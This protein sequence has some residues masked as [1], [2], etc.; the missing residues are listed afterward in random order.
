MKIRVYYE[1][2]DIAGVVYYAN[3]FKFIERARSE[4]FFSQGISPIDGASHFV[5]KSVS[6][7]FLASAKFGDEIDVRTR[8][9]DMKSASL[10]LGQDIYRDEQLLFAA[11]VKLVHLNQTK[12]A[13]IPDSLKKLFI[14]GE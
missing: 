5:V 8:L 12:P 2:T 11:T 9:V 7:D 3:Y 13:K 10:V 1:D 14:T 6:A 4:L